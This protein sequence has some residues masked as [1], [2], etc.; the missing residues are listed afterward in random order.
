MPS[1]LWARRFARG[2][3]VL[4]LI[5]SVAACGSSWWPFQPST[6]TTAPTPTPS[7]T[8][9]PTPISTLDAFK[10]RVIS[11]DF[12]AQGTVAGTV[13]ARLIIGSS[14]G[15]VTGTFKVKAGDSDASINAVILGSTI[16]YD[17]IV[18]GGSSYSRTN[19]GQWS[20][21][22]ASGKTLQGFVSSGIVIVD[23]GPEPMFGRQLHHLTVADMAGVDPSAFGISAGSSMQNLTLQSLSFWAETDGTPAGVSLQ[24]TF[25]QQILGTPTHETVTL[26]IQ[27]EALSGVT[28]TAPAT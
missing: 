9:T 20:Q 17:S 2:A 4:L 21:S 22:P 6:P 19:G 8:P 18:V 28:I 12:Q 11:G 1:T 13:N 24:A 15:P 27:I 16:T 10:A 7:P 26:D 5:G 25:D 3:A 14:S 23:A